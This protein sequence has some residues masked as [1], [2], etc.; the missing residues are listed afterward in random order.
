MGINIRPWEWKPR[1]WRGSGHRFLQV[2]CLR[3][4]IKWTYL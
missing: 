2:G 4:W 3:L 1:A